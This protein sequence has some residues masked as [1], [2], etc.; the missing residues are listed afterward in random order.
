M[1]RALAEQFFDPR[2]DEL[3]FE[4]LGQHP[5]APGGRRLRLIHG[6]ERP[7]Q[8]QDRNVPQPRRLLDVVRH[9]VSGPPGHAD[10]DQHDIGRLRFDALDRLIAVADG[11]DLDVLVCEGQLDH[12][13]NGHAV[14]GEKK[15]LRHLGLIGQTR[16]I[17]QVRVGS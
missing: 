6:L 16:S 13:L 2:D 5:V 3:R 14:V 12:A 11:D 4:R 7:G 10:I 8:Q 15:S 9:L 1:L 17:G